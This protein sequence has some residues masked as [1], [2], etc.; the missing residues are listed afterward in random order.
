[1]EKFYYYEG[2]GIRYIQITGTT[3]V[4]DN[5]VEL[6]RFTALGEIDGDAKAREFIDSIIALGLTNALNH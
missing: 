6:T 3:L 2:Y 1:M 4:E 5:G